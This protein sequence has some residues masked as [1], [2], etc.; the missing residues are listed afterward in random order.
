M[1]RS[2]EIAKLSVGLELQSESFSKQLTRVSKETRNLEKDFNVAKKAIDNA[3]DSM[4][5]MENALSKGQKAIDSLNKKIELQ[6]QRYQTL[7]KTTEKQSNSY[8]DLQ[9]ELKKLETDL[10]KLTKEENINEQAIASKKAEIDEVTSKMKNYQDLIQKNSLKLQQYATDIDKT[11]NS[12]NKMQ[13]EIKSVSDSLSK[14]KFE[15]AISDLRRFQDEC[16]KLQTTLDSTSE[17]LE[18][19]SDKTEKLSKA[20]SVFAVASKLAYLESDSALGKIKATLGQTEQEAKK[21]LDRVKELASK[22]FNFDEAVDSIVKVEQALGDMLSPE[23]ID[24]MV[25]ELSVISKYFEVDVQD[26]I[27]AVSMMMKNFGI[28]GQEAT[29]IIAYGLQNG[30]NISDD[31]I[32][33]LWEYSYQFADMGFTAEETLAIISHGVKDGAFNTDKLADGVKEFNLRLSE[34][35]KTQEDALKSLGLNVEEVTNA[36]NTGGEAGKNMAL[37]VALELSKVENETKRNSLAVALFGTQ[38]EDVGDSI[39]NALSGVSEAN[40]NVKGSADEVKKAFEESLGAQVAGKINQLKEPLIALGEQGLIPILDSTLELTDE[41]LKWFETLDEGT[42]KAMA[43]FGM[44]TIV[45]TPLLKLFSSLASAGS[46]FINILSLLGSKI[47]GIGTITGSTTSVFSKFSSL[48]SALPG[49]PIMLLISA[50]VGLASVMGDNQKAILELQDKLGGFGTILGGVCEFIS[51]TVQLTFSNVVS[52][53]QL[54]IDSIAA[55]VDGPGGATIEQAWKN[56]S[57]RLANNIREGVDKITLT[58]TTGL[59]HMRNLSDIE[60]N[61]LVNSMTT[62]MNNIPS[63]VNGNYTEATQIL[64]SQLS[65]MSNSQI[66]SLQGLSDTTRNLFRNIRE[67]MT[68]DEI[69]PILNNN[70]TSMKNSGKLNIETLEKEISSSMAMIESQMSTKSKDGTTKLSSNLN[71]AKNSVKSSADKM[72]QD[73]SVGMS[74]VANNFMNASG[75]IP[76]DVKNNMDKSVMAVKQAG[77]DMYNGVKTSFYKMEEVSK[78]HATNLYLGVQTSASKMA[79]SVKNSATDMYKGVTNSTSQMANKAISDWNRIRSA[80]SNPVRASISVTKTQTTVSRY[81]TESITSRASDGARAYTQDTQLQRAKAPNIDTYDISG[82][83][84][85]KSSSNYNFSNESNLENEIIK[86]NNLL[87]NL[88]DLVKNK[89]INKDFNIVVPVNLDEKEIT[90]VVSRNLAYNVRR[91]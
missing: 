87:S 5:A 59:S 50:L 71:Q 13:N 1:S 72:A 62:I 18:D 76:T 28:S 22:G 27:K 21:T 44:F 52:W 16:Q 15:E 7:Y 54:A 85:N 46:G 56:H 36:F 2:E 39:I 66:N 82:G 26:S 69:I 75:K 41:F 32:D 9:V 34:V 65:N 45:L 80:Y 23:E 55:M 64:S 33:T 84:Y 73:S 78:Q 86:Q 77:S 47:S 48:L 43:K 10:S 90:R 70:F 4:E 63:I 19:M 6:E 49:G 40:L 68:I 79:S 51:G 37:K 31:F 20:S 24:D 91:I 57:E 53:V 8:K 42:I 61:N 25:E 30:L 89:D 60:L 17:K 67:G 88:I 12:L 3:E 11:K 58:T 74:N 29:D 81:K 38:Y 14:A 35:G 83:Y